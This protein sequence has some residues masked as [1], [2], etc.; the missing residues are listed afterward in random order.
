ML[1]VFIA[2][3][4]FPFR[5]FAR[6]GLLLAI[7]VP[8]LVAL[9]AGKE[10]L[11]YLP[12]IGTVEAEN[13]TYRQ[14]LVEISMREILEHPLFGVFDYI[15]SPAM[16]ELKQGQGIIDIVNTYMG[17]GLSS[18]L[19]G[20]SIFA[21]FFAAVVLG[22]FRNM[23]ELADR[24]AENYLLGRILL[25]TLLGILV[26]IFAVSNILAIPVIYWSVA[27]LGVA[28]ARMLAVAK[29]PA[30]TRPVGFIRWAEHCLQHTS[31]YRP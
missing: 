27:G 10:I 7:A 29:A 24:N 25:A 26:M 13:I 16:Q 14:R 8:L 19:A 31:G 5:G 23:R 15:Y 6:L 12:F 11:D 2:T 17:I 3:G 21:G 1:I 9:P 22:I 18:G 28:Y 30:A 20:L 4:P